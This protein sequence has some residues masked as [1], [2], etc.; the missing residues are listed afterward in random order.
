MQKS[1]AFLFANNEQVEFEIK[2]TIPIYI[3][4]PKMKHWSI[5][6]IKYVQDLYEENYKTDEWN[7]RTK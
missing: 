3:S 1:V 4:T 6:L 2:S 5:Y 7:Q